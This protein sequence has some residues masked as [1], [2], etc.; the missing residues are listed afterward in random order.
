[1]ILFVEDTMVPYILN[2]RDGTIFNLS[3]YHDIGVDVGNLIPHG[4]FPLE[5]KES[6]SFELVYIPWLLTTEEAYNDFVTI[7]LGDYYSSNSYVLFQTTPVTVYVIDCLMT[8]IR[9]R[10]GK[11]PFIIQTLED[12]MRTYETSMTDEG[13]ATFMKDKELHTM[14]TFNPESFNRILEEAERYNGSTV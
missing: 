12:T 8:L 1:M 6:D 14:R 11:I 9:K 7:M 13:I 5:Y 10:Y 4:D 2:K 3:S